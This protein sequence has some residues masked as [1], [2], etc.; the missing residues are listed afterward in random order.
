MRALF[1]QHGPLLLFSLLLLSLLL[2][3]L[4]LLSQRLLRLLW[5]EVSG[6]LPLRRLLSQQASCKQGLGR[7][8]PRG[9]RQV[10]IH[11]GR[12]GGSL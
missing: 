10:E 9:P 12:G 4:L 2:L 11:H 6:Q 7:A 8:A 5:W 3:S 1:I